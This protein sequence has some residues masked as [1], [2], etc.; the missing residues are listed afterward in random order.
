MRA[1]IWIGI[2]IVV[3]S[4]STDREELLSP[5]LFTNP[6][7]KTTGLKFTNNLTESDSLNILDYLYFYNG[8]GVA[9]GDINNDGL[10]DIYLSGN[11]VKNK[12]Y[13]NKG[14][15][16][17]EDITD[18]AGVGGKSSWNTGT[19]MFDANQDGLLDIYVCAVVGINDFKG[20]NELFINNGDSTFTE[21]A[22]EYGL[23][24]T[25][26]STT[27]AVLDYDKDG[28]L[29]L[30]LLNHAVHTQ[31][32]YGTSD[33]RYKRS[34]PSSDKLLRNDGGTF[35][36]V[37][38]PM[39]LVGGINSYGLG[40]SIADF[41]KDGWPDIY[42]GN[43]FHE[44]DYYYINEGG[45]RFRESL[46][47]KFSH[48]S[49][50]S[51]G[52][53]VADINGD[54]YPDLISLDMAPESERVL[55]SS[56][57]D[58]NIQTQKIRVER[59]GYHYQFTRNM[60][61]INQPGYQFREQALLSGVSATDWSWSALFAD[62][63]NDSYQD[64]FISNG[65]PK[66]P[67]DL[68][69]INFISN[70]EIQNRLNQSRLIDQT[71]LAK[72]PSGS[73]PNY[74][75]QGSENYLFKDRS[76][77]WTENRPNV[78]GATALADFDNDGSI[79]LVVNTI[80]EPVK[81]YHNQNNKKKNWLKLKLD[82]LQSNR[83]GIGTKVYVYSKGKMQYKELYTARGF[84]AS[85]EPILHFGLDDIKLVDSIKIV[86]PDDTFQ[87]LKKIS[88]N[89][90]LTIQPEG[91]KEP[92]RAPADKSL[93]LF[94]KT[95]NNLSIDFS[96]QEDPYVDFNRQK[97][98][99]FK[100]SDRGPA[101]AVGDINGD[102]LEDIYFGGSKF[103]PS[104][105]YVQ[106]DG[107]FAKAYTEQLKTHYATED[108]T[109]HIQ[110]GKII[111]GTAGGDYSVTNPGL[112]DYILNL[113]DSLKTPLSD[114]RGNTSII[115]QND[116]DNDGDIDLFVGH[117]AI[118]GDYGRIPE[119]YLLKNNNHLFT[120]DKKNELGDLGMVTDAIW[121]DFTGD[122]ID[123]LI[124]IG[125]W[126][127]VQFYENKKGILKR[128]KVQSERLKGLWQAIEPFDIDQDGD[129]DYMLGNWGTNS[130][131]TA[132]LEKPLRMYYSDFDKN[133]Q[134]ETI[135]ATSKEG[136]YYPIQN[137]RSLSEQLIPL[138]KKYPNNT[139]FAGQTVG[140]IFGKYALENAEL[141][142]VNTLKSGYLKNEKGTFTFVPFPSIMQVAPIL[143]FVV[144]DFD[145]DLQ[146]EVLAGGNYFGVKPYHGR[147]DSFSGAL[148]KNENT[149]VEGYKVGLDFAQKSVRHLNTINVAGE[150]FLLVTF[151]NQVAEIYTINK[152][153]QQ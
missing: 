68:D 124:V 41:N 82:D 141:L 62:F 88:S 107:A 78:S 99:P 36:E 5:K 64:L 123:D 117:H 116:Y 1:G 138:K 19:I 72:M 97:L 28:D 56:E 32:S 14:D 65:I 71:A 96:H 121:S 37:S 30:Y 69:F 9:V 104:A 91:V 106:S 144:A 6:N 85:S 79:D 43:D 86:W 55:K 3:I 139:K 22:K 11:Q 114:I 135:I 143:D 128:V 105:I 112:E 4:C 12:L 63:N 46:K 84:Q 93:Q 132:T 125:E 87:T 76:E 102:G 31:E 40:V 118:T 20:N 52:N 90:L 122:G 130:K 67:N 58:D 33:L 147:L 101:T 98:I 8:G 59:F 44:D 47:E 75:Y 120:R 103:I 131:F 136:Q 50:F 83:F 21:S 94:S 127:T 39:G 73:V 51:M 137:L 153:S 149:I 42:V 70:T 45:A 66:R 142:E 113:A 109:A 95:E 152:K 133:G 80:N 126:M 25:T 38:E 81:I 115:A 2:F 148:I 53:D 134:T 145:G 151:N 16:K 15:L 129:V 18:K 29:D 60:L 54:G 110:D 92:E 24:F 146:K 49:R 7:A 140:Q 57:G 35:T 100:I 23:D 27:A 74:V 13:I 34:E 48:T 150:E 111:V 119:S 108:K 26:F 17:F 61:F 10:S 89:Q 77:D